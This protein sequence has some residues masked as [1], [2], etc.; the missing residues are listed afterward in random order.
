MAAGDVAGFV[1]EHA[2]QFVRI[3]SRENEAGVEED[4][5]PARDEGVKRGIIENVNVDV[6]GIETGRREDRIAIDAKVCSISASRID[7]ACRVGWASRGEC[8]GERNQASLRRV[9]RACGRKQRRCVGRVER[10][11]SSGSG[12]VRSSG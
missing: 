3:L 8:R 2:D 10:M 4:I 12:C 7:A 9:R 6:V 1:R 11:R 5:L